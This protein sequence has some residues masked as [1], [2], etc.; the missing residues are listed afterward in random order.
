MTPVFSPEPFSYSS[1]VAP[2]EPLQQASVLSATALLFGRDEA[3]MD[4]LYLDLRRTCA[5]GVVL[6]VGCG[7]GRFVRKLIGFGVNAYGV[8]CD[9]A[10]VAV[11]ERLIPGRC[12]LAAGVALPVSDG[13][14]DTVVCCGGVGALKAESVDGRIKEIHRIVRRHVFLVVDTS[15]FPDGTHHGREWWDGQFIR[16]GFR[17]HPG[18]FRVVDYT[19][20]D[21][22]QARLVLLYEKIDDPVLAAHPLARLA[23]ERDLH[24]DMLREAGRR[25]DA[26]LQRYA[27]AATLVRPNDTVLDVA[28]GLGY[29]LAVIATEGR[30]EKL[31][32]VDSSEYAIHYA[33]TMFG[34]GAHHLDFRVGDA[35]TLA[36]IPAHSID[37]VVSFETL[38]HLEHPEVFLEHVRR[39]LV[40]G[41]RFVGSVPN[42][43]LDETGRDPN[44][45]H[46]H[47]FD[48][49][50]LLAL[51]QPPFLVESLFAETAGGGGK[52]LCK[53]IRAWWRVDPRGPR[54]DDAE[55]WLV[56]AMKDPRQGATVPYVETMNAILPGTYR[57]AALAYP[58]A[59][60]NPWI[61]HAL[62]TAGARIGDP[63]LLKQLAE[64]VEWASPEGSVDRGA[65]LCVA[66]Y[67]LLQSAGD[68][69]E[70]KRNLLQRI[71][72]W[73]GHAGDSIHHW[74]WSV[75]LEFLAGQLNL[76]I[77]ERAQ[78]LDW[79][80]RCA[81][82]DALRFSPLLATKTVEAAYLAGL[83]H[84]WDR[85][86]S[87]ARGFWVEGLRQA[88]RACTGD[89]REIVGDLDAP[90]IFGLREFAQVLDQATKCAVGLRALKNL[91]S[92][93]GLFF[94]LLAGNSRGELD[95][96][97]ELHHRVGVRN[98]VEEREAGYATARREIENQ[99]TL[100]LAEIAAR[101]AEQHQ[102]ALEQ[103][104]WEIERQ[105]HVEALRQ[106]AAEEL[107]R[108]L[109]LLAAQ[110]AA[111]A[112]VRPLV[113]WGCG[114]GGRRVLALL[115]E[116]G[117][118]VEAFI[119][120]DPR[121]AGSL[122]EGVPVCSP[123]AVVP[124]GE[125]RVFV[126]V[127]SVHAA[128]IKAQLQAA[129]LRPGDDFLPID[130]DAV[131]K[132]EA[133]E[134]MTPR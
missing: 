40:P 64:Q 32:G 129:G 113:I 17:R 63:I 85:N 133:Q 75:S 47:V 61:R 104:Q 119:D 106:N 125:R 57:P 12:L 21:F 97:K 83:I 59:Y 27:F 109:R 132:L 7:D 46:L 26:H 82:R 74:R 131:A 8:D 111:V 110:S 105:R 93:P 121:K 56:V 78:A 71:E 60:L 41:G 88:G 115:Q 68:D 130:F 20:L 10:A 50:R 70:V 122:L 24:M 92:A 80:S 42:E 58:D 48:A 55:W 95:W 84:A 3:E 112:E 11:A 1:P 22:E 39:V 103:Q 33:R 19:R 94:D 51:F 89:W 54:D 69:G 5:L 15:P 102:R 29:G 30:A 25:S 86:E 45:H 100:L 38:E 16:A 118:L 65:V 76:R 116:A 53:P 123:A 108:L 91:E 120:S 81:G 28:C 77:G 44:P 31:I 72:G 99:H 4:V 117:G 107:Q 90:L 96:V 62:V 6:E 35:Q 23:E 67:Q 9:Q 73:I 14:V 79:F 37:L 98:L 101:A 2:S 52:T 124:T 34:G 87:A 49:R 126:L 13:S 18:L 114:S 36:G 128:A 127:A 43:W 66:G 134:T